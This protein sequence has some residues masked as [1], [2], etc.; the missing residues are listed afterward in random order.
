MGNGSSS[1][2]KVTPEYCGHECQKNKEKIQYYDEWMEYK[3]ECQKDYPEEC[4]PLGEWKKKKQ[5]Y[6]QVFGDGKEYRA[7]LDKEQTGI[8][9]NFRGLRNINY[10]P[11][12]N[13][14]K[15]LALMLIYQGQTER[16]LNEKKNVLERTINKMKNY[17]GNF[18]LSTSKWT[19][20]SQYHLE[21]YKK[22][23]DL[24]EKIKKLIITLS[25]ICFILIIFYSGFLTTRK[26]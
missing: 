15:T 25:F 4:R 26:V 7:W 13:Y 21:N 9:N 22:K 12:E 14:Q 20:K 3:N 8:I 17:I 11:L 10:F 23:L 1:D 6:K 18:E 19:R 2:M 5:Y 24:S 16:L